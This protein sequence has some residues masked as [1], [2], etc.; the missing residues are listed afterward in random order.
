[1]NLK[2]A[3]VDDQVSELNHLIDLIHHNQKDHLADFD[4]DIYHSSTDFF[5]HFTSNSYHIIFL[6]VFIENNKGIDVSHSIRRIDSNVKLIF[7]AD[8]PD[9]ALEGYD[10]HAYAYLLKPLAYSHVERLLKEIIFEFDL[11]APYINVKENRCNIKILLDDIIYVDVDNHYL[12]I[13]TP[14]RTIRTYMRFRDFEPMLSKFSQFLCC[15]R[16]VLVNMD[17]IQETEDMDFKMDNGDYVPIRRNAKQEMRQKYVDYM[18]EK[19][20]QKIKN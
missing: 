3:I 4:Y 5:K 16:N 8:S 1:M 14:L 17:H 9:L 2:I 15:Y 20:N 11:Q 19:T 12:Q 13:H 10:V 6:N 7:T 18:F